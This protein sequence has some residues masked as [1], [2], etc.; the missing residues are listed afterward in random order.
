MSGQLWYVEKIVKVS[1]LGFLELTRCV[2]VYDRERGG[3]RKLRGREDDEDEREARHIDWEVTDR[4]NYSSRQREGEITARSRAS[5]MPVRARECVLVRTYLV[6]LQTACGLW[7]LFEIH[8]N[9]G[10]MGGERMCSRADSVLISVITAGCTQCQIH[11]LRSTWAEHR[12]TSQK[13]PALLRRRLWGLWSCVPDGFG[14]W[15]KI[16]FPALSLSPSG[17]LREGRRSWI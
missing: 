12:H 3:M 14:V 16:S 7:V 2:C 4:C 8:T 13:K 9:G 10:Y 1:S 11:M 17:E 5:H 6:H 15:M